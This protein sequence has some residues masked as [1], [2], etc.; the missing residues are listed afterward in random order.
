[1]PL[2]SPWHAAANM[3]GVC[4]LDPAKAK[5]H[6][7]FPCATASFSRFADECLAGC[8]VATSG[9]AASD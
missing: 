2:L 5:R 1:M 6:N 7:G 4:L 9:P 8:G 3:R